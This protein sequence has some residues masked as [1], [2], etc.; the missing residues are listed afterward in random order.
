MWCFIAVCSN[1]EHL[2]PL[3]HHFKNLK[4]TVGSILQ[5]CIMLV[6]A[7]IHIFH[8]MIYVTDKIILGLQV[9]CCNRTVYGTAL[10]IITSAL[11][12]NNKSLHAAA[13]VTQ[14]MWLK[15]YRLYSHHCDYTDSVAYPACNLKHIGN[16]SGE[17]SAKGI[18]LTSHLNMSRLRKYRALPLYPCVLTK[19]CL[20]RSGMI[21][22][23]LL[24]YTLKLTSRHFIA[25][26]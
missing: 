6:T 14:D 7:I 19:W 17:W 10:C 21:F 23:F 24:V 9:P 13:S 8:W 5:A 3:P 15:T 25:M 12:R 1:P 11:N 2:N 18:Q 26:K 4:Y 16:W 20:I 22:T